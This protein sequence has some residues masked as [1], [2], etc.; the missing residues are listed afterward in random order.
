MA[1]GLL[2][3][4][5]NVEVITTHLLRFRSI[6]MLSYSLQR[7]Y[8]LPYHEPVKMLNRCI[9]SHGTQLYN[10]SQVKQV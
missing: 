7:S 3:F 1:G 5:V 2:D 8:T 9:G 4:T 6:P 10:E